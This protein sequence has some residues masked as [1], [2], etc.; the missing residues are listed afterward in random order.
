MT[1][2]RRLRLSPATATLLVALAL[3]LAALTGPVFASCSPSPADC[4]GCC[5][6]NVPET[7]D[8]LAPLSSG[9][10]SLEV[11]ALATPPADP[12]PAV[13]AVRAALPWAQPPPEAP[14]LS[15]SS[16]RAPPA[17]PAA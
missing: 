5:L 7:V 12:A 16:P 10:P 6:Q 9:R 4:C 11:V 3:V 8:T 17:A 15:A 13:P 1:T 14:L 2:P